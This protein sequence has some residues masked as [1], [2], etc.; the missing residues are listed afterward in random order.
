MKASFVVTNVSNLR[1]RLL[2]KTDRI[3]RF[4]S[5]ANLA[6]SPLISSEDETSG[7]EDLSFLDNGSPKSSAVSSAELRFVHDRSFIDLHEFTNHGG[8]VSN[9]QTAGGIEM[10]TIRYILTKRGW[11]FRQP[12][13]YGVDL[14]EAIVVKALNYLFKE[15]A[16]AALSLCFFRW[17]EYSVGFKHTIRSV[18]TMICILVFGN[19]NHRVM[20]LLKDLVQDHVGEDGY[21]NLLLNAIQENC[22]GGWVLETVHSM[23]VQCYVELNMINAA[24]EL[25]YQMEHF[26]IVPSAGACNSLVKSLLESNQE[27][28][29]WDL[30]EAMR[31]HA[32]VN[33]S[34]IS[35]FIYHYCCKGNIGCGWKL[36]L[37]MRNYGVKP[38]IVA[39]SIVIHSLCKMACLKEATLVL[40]K[41][42]K[43]GFLP[44]SVLL[45]SIIDGYCKMA[46]QEEA[47]R[48]INTFNVPPN[49]FV[50]NS[51]ISK[52]CKDGDMVQASNIFSEMSESGFLPDCISYTTMISGYCK[53]R[54]TG[55][56]FQY[57]GRMLKS[58]IQ[59]SVTTYTALIEY[60]CRSGEMEMAEHLF[61]KMTD[62]GLRPDVVVYNALING[63]GR[64]GQL[65]KAFELCDIMK[66]AGVSPDSVTY[67][68]IIHS[69]VVRGFVNEARDILNELIRRGFSPD[70]ITFTDIIGGFSNRGQ[71]EEAFLVWSYMSK[72]NTKPDV[73][74]CSALLNGYC[75]ARRMEEASALF[76]KM[77]D[78]GLTPDLILYNTLIHGFC[79]MGNINDACNLISMMVKQNIMPNDV[80]YRAL[81]LGYEK[82]CVNHPAKS[83][84]SKLQHILREHGLHVIDC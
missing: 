24:V 18:C 62:K 49:I 78:V 46:R 33:A 19:L 68:I 58:G 51:F 21:H 38:D 23:L 40:F 42:I 80:T 83:A 27:E 56:A 43:V 54:D 20:D 2:T 63:Y 75:R 53:A 67:N 60:Y 69:L 55:K 84:G 66:Y 17:L 64:K 39:Y 77:L 16:D 8:S 35:L 81:I 59:P 73:V 76:H 82:K 50:Y 11:N 45:S 36:T 72:F 44:D 57:L 10:E 65:H 31:R 47:I 79:S 25:V 37:D 3:S 13:G 22:T 14:S 29:A 12:D 61:C 71:F 26:G 28:L 7:L 5:S 52:F 32:M 41:M 9:N 15:S 34:H 30:L 4:F 74:T 48:I 70:L 1:L 6:F